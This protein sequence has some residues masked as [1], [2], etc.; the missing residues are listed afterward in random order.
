[1]S[2]DPSQPSTPSSGERLLSRKEVCEAL[3]LSD[4]TVR[5]LDARGDLHPTQDEK[6]QWW[7]SMREVQEFAEAQANTPAAQHQAQQQQQMVRTTEV[8]IRT[9]GETGMRESVRRVHEPISPEGSLAQVVAMMI[10]HQEKDHRLLHE[11]LE[12]SIST[13]RDAVKD[14]NNACKEKDATIEKL[15]AEKR[16]DYELV[17]ELKNKKADRDMEVKKEEARMKL[18]EK[19]GEKVMPILPIVLSKFFGWLAPGGKAPSAPGDP[20]TDEELVIDNLLES[21]KGEQ[22]AKLLEVLTPE[23]GMLIMQLYE[24]YT[25][26]KEAAGKQVFEDDPT[27]PGAQP[28]GAKP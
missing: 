4:A 1:M 17:E 28:P 23:Q 3:G 6:N 2:S 13:M 25:A 19:A 27:K 18:I 22:T 9:D 26:K 5:R 8:A 24:K 20:Q 21:L 14:A 7:Y 15:V 10:Q 11:I 16:E 12:T